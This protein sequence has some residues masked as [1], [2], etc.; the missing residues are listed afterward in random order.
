A[1]MSKNTAGF[2]V[3]AIRENYPLPAELKSDSTPR[4]G[5][6]ARF[7]I[8]PIEAPPSSENPDAETRLAIDSFWQTLS[9]EQQIKFEA[10]AVSAAAPFL[11]KQYEDRKQSG[12]HLFEAARVAILEREIKKRIP[13]EKAA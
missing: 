5:G 8:L 6:D 1:R 9:K 7:R 3:K 13:T 2:L 11:K 10:D 12:G 4:S